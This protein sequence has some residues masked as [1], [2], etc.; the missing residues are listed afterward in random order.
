MQFILSCNSRILTPFELNTA[1]FIKEFSHLIRENLTSQST[2]KIVRIL[3][4]KT[5]EDQQNQGCTDR[6]GFGERNLQEKYTSTRVREYQSTQSH[7]TSEYTIFLLTTALTRP[8]RTGIRS[9]QGQGVHCACV[10][11]C[12]L[13]MVLAC[14]SAG[15]RARVLR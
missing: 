5:G 1:Y 15:C 8:E 6:A 9:G 11:L 10:F 12:P 2:L 3:V 13:L 7:I 14:W 4:Q